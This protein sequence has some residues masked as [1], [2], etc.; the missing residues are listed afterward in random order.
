MSVMGCLVMC[1]KPRQIIARGANN[2]ASN[3]GW[4][5]MGS[6]GLPLLWGWGTMLGAWGLGLGAWGF[7]L[8][9]MGKGTAR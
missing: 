2:V 4:S 8:W 7:G 5:G 3:G 9:A 6:N 1:Q